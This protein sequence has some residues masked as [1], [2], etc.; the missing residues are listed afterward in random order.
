MKA[1]TIDPEDFRIAVENMDEE[2]LERLVEE[3][4]QPLL[5]LEADDFFGPEGINN[6]FR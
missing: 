3:L 6:R 5:D 1:L 4:Q 2:M